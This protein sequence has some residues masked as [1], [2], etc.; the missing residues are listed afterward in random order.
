M[1]PKQQLQGDRSM[2]KMMILGLLLTTGISV[3]TYARPLYICD[4]KR[5]KVS[6]SICDKSSTEEKKQEC[7]SF[8]KNADCN[9]VA[10][11]EQ[12]NEE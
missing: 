7:I 3:Q 11:H 4:K 5:D 6:L 10:L 8:Y 9:T 1:Q 12:Y 2:N